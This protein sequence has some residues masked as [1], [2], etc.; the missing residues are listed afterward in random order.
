M[1][2]KRLILSSYG[3]KGKNQNT[4]QPGEKPFQQRKA[5]DGTEQASIKES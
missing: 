2:D 4:G 5:F 1:L 3:F